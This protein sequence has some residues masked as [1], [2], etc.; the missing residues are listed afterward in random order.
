[1]G[2][3]FDCDENKLKCLL[4][5]ALFRNEEWEMNGRTG[6]TTKCCSLIPADDIRSGKFKTPKDKPRQDRPASTPFE[7]TG[8]KDFEALDDDDDLP[9]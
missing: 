5:G 8:P 2:F 3:R 6:W 4:V 7:T 9:F 1:M